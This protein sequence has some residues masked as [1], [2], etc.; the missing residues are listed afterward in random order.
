MS[1]AAFRSRFLLNRICLAVAALE[2]AVAPLLAGA[3]KET[4]KDITPAEARKHVGENVCVTMFVKKTKDSPKTKRIYLDSELDYRDAKNLGILIEESAKS[5][6]K[7]AGIVEPHV[8]YKDKTIR[9]TGKPFIEDDCV[10]IKVEGPADIAVVDI[11]QP[12]DQR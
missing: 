5:K 3:Q 7:D 9:V 12:A 6:F 1:A 10:F 4:P 11:T 8:H 2:L